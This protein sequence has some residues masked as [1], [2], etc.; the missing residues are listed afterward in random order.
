MHV[1]LVKEFGVDD[2]DFVWIDADARAWRAALI[3]II[4]MSLLD[5]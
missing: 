1:E 3:V 5:R 2:V 4:S